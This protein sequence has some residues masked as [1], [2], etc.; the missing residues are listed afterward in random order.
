MNSVADH[1]THRNQPLMN[2]DERRS[3]HGQFLLK[4]GSQYPDNVVS[5]YPAEI[6]DRFCICVYPCVS[7]AIE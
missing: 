2:T 3:H 5:D 7:A 6:P 4:T 1:Q